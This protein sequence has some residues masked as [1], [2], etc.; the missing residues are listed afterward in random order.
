MGMRSAWF[1]MLIYACSDVGGNW[2]V[3]CYETIQRCGI[4]FSVPCA[5]HRAKQ[6]HIVMCVV[7]G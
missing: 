5:C 2:I 6:Q 3:M 7:W 1:V 4:M